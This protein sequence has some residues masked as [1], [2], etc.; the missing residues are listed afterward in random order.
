MRTYCT[1]HNIKILTSIYFTVKIV[2]HLW[3]LHLVQRSSHKQ[4]HEYVLWCSDY[5]STWL[6][7]S[8]LLL[9]LWSTGH[10]W[11]ALF[12]FSFL[13]LR[14][15]VGFLGRGISTSQSRYLHRTTQT[16]NKRRH[17]SMLE[18]NSNPRSQCSSERRQFMRQTTRPLWS[19]VRDSI[20]CYILP[21]VF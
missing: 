7:L 19:A 6:S 2:V 12:Y 17:T 11:N 1:Q 20:Y 21:N 3:P 8:F 10:P 18:W 5:F 9:P 16:K 14:H 13:N 4:L 15:S